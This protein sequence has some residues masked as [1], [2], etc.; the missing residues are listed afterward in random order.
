[1]KKP[2]YITIACFIFITA[3]SKGGGGSNGNPPTTVPSPVASTLTS[4]LNNTACL[5]G[6]PVDAN[7]A[8]ITFSWQAATNAET[9]DLVVK[10]LISAQQT[11]YPVS[12]TTKDIVLSKTQPY[13]WYVV[14]KSSKTTTTAQSAVWKFYVAGNP[15]SSYAPFPA[16]IIAPSANAV[17]GS[18]GAGQVNVVLQWDA[19]DIDNDIVSYAIFLDNKDAS[20]KIIPSIVAKTTSI[21]LASGKTY[22]WRVV[23]TDGAGN[24]AD[25]GIYSFTIQ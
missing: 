22:Y 20:T 18:G 21:S 19:T 25:S 1:M 3:C 10:N 11:T 16:I 17:I 24:S 12:A 14:S 8:T 23:T 7:N 6:A 4:P 15:T 13:S 2:V 5:S 9:Y